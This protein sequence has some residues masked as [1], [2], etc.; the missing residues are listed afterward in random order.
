MYQTVGPAV[1]EK[2]DDN[3]QY[4]SKFYLKFSIDIGKPDKVLE[5]KSVYL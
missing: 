3:R 1:A 5:D 4:I 2:P